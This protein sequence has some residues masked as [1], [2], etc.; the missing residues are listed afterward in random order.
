M[1]IEFYQRTLAQPAGQPPQARPAAEDPARKAAVQS[2]HQRSA[3]DLHARL[4]A[5]VT[6]NELDG[7]SGE[8]RI[9]SMSTKGLAF[10]STKSLKGV[11]SAPALSTDLSR[12]ET[13]CPGRV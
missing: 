11:Q 6:T 1:V 13:R 10:V 2:R 5:P 3:D 4:I 8:R 9:Y 12:R 7:Q